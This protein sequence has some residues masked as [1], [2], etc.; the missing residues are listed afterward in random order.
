[1]FVWVRGPWQEQEQDRTSDGIGG[2]VHRA[3]P[4]AC[5]VRTLL[6]RP[7]PL[8]TPITALVGMGILLFSSPSILH[9]SV[10]QAAMFP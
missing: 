7:H 1:M 5:A 2:V 8:C 3:I 4:A 9:A 10:G 6:S